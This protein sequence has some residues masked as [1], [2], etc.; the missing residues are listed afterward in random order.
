MLIGIDMLGV[1]SPEGSDRPAGRYGRQLVSALLAGDHANSYI[2]YAHQD[3]SVDRMPSAPRARHVSLPPISAGATRLRPTIQ[4]VID[5]NPDGLDWLLLLDPFEPNYGGLAPE[6]SRNTLKVASLVHDLTPGLDDERRLMP[7]RRHHAILTLSDSTATHC[8]KRLG[9]SPSRV[10]NLG[11]AIDPSAESPD[12]TDPGP[13]SGED[14]LE[15]LGIDGPF[16]LAGVAPGS[17]WADL[18][19]VLD[20]YR[21]LS[22]ERRASQRLVIAGPFEDPWRVISYLREFD[23]AERLVLVGDLR[24][25]AI[26]KLY[27]GCTA[28]LAPLSV[29]ASGLSIVEAMNCGSPVIADANGH[30]ASI[31]GEAGLLVDRSDPVGIAEQLEGLLSDEKVRDVLKQKARARSAQFS[32]APVISAL[33][34][35]LESEKPGRRAS[36]MRVDKGHVVRP[37]IAIHLDDP[38]DG[39][40]FPEVDELIPSRWREEF[41]LDLYLEPGSAAQF[42]DLRSDFHTF[43]SRRFD[44]KDGLLGYD[45]VVYHFN[46]PGCLELKLGQMR[47]RPGLV[48]LGDEFILRR[49]ADRLREVLETSSLVVVRSRYLLDLARKLLPESA[50]RLIEYPPSDAF[51]D[52]IP[53]IDE[54]RRCTSELGRGPVGQLSTTGRGVRDEV[55]TPRFL[56]SVPISGD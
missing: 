21:A 54:I 25:R 55:T 46:D 5:E 35:R 48:I 14:G 1:Q 11:L 33:L 32:W 53:L 16:L 24:S 6:S 42:R 4:R 12:L 34:E 29:A 3:M 18:A 38:L 26:L 22:A 39:S 13:E 50:T 23:C 2:L 51:D 31:V 20:A 56:Q 36:R 28:F 47:R 43:E 27:R 30:H 10:T 41:D 52:S 44:R 19:P 7:L 45:A 15:E 37:R 40:R 8:R 17:T 49:D 9:L